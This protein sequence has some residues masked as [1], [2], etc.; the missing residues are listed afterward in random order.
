MT[1]HAKAVVTVL[2]TA[3]ITLLGALALGLIH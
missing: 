1:P 2:A 3:A